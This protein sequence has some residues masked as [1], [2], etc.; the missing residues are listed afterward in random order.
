MRKAEPR[1]AVATERRF[2]PAGAPVREEQ[3]LVIRPA[4]PDALDR[5]CGHV[6]ILPVASDDSQ[7]AA[8]VSQNSV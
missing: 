1:I 5:T 3:P 8:H 2:M 6:H 4:V 7:N